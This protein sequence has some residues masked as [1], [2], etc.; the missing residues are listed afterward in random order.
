MVI[1]AST[2]KLVNLLIMIQQRRSESGQTIE[3]EKKSMRAELC[4]GDTK[5]NQQTVIKHVG[6][7]VSWDTTIERP[8]V[9]H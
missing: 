3:R 7:G 4:F 1:V 9:S 8:I 6:M 5:R 2:C